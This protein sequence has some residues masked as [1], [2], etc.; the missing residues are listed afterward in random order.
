MTEKLRLCDGI[1][2]E[3]LQGGG[4]LGYGFAGRLIM[5]FLPA[6]EDN[7]WLLIFIIEKHFGESGYMYGGIVLHS[8]VQ[9]TKKYCLFGAFEIWFS[10]NH[11][12]YIMAGE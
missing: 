5:L 1:V 6:R 10:K 12:E 4:G 11:C 9:H 8:C 7:L 2:A 3:L